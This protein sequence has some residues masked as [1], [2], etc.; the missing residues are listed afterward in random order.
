M[1]DR[2]QRIR[3]WYRDVFTAQLGEAVIGADE[4]VVAADVV[5]VI[6][7][8]AVGRHG[9]GKLTPLQLD[10][11]RE[12]LPG[13]DGTVMDLG[14]VKLGCGTTILGIGFALV[15]ALAV[16]VVEGDVTYAGPAV[17]DYGCGMEFGHGVYG[18]IVCITKILNDVDSLICFFIPLSLSTG[19][20]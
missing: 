3:L 12:L 5:I 14:L 16:T 13:K 8:R 7:W 11:V 9:F 17:L 19:L 20:V 1:R 10:G 18:I 15:E 4:E 2:E 6:I